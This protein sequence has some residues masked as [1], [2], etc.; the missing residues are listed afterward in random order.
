M[1]EY[2]TIIGKLLSGVKRKQFKRIV[3]KYDGDKYVKYFNCWSQ[4]VCIFIGQ[5]GNFKSLR[6]IVDAINFQPQNQ[7]HLGIKKNISRTTLAEANEKRDWRIYRDVFLKLIEKLPHW[8]RIETENVIKIMDSSPIQ[9]KLL[10]HPWVEKTQRIEGIKLHLLYDLTNTIPTYFEFSG[11]RTNDIEI[12]KRMDI[13]TGSTYVFDKGYMDFNWWNEIDDKGA[14]FVTRLKKNNAYD[15]LTPIQIHSDI[16]SSQII[17][18][19]RKRFKDGRY[20]Y[21]S[22]KPLRKVIVQR[23]GKSPLLLVTNDFNRSSEEIGELYKQRWQ[24]ELFF[25][26]IKQNLKIKNFLGRSENA[27]KTQIC[28]ALISFV[29]LHLMN[30]LKEICSEISTK[31]LLKIIGNNMFYTLKPRSAGRRRYKNPN[32]LQIEWILD[33]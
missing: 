32:Q 27:V 28:I 29:L 16:V 19:N 6:E 23:E 25:K 21:Y 7:Y 8:K 11:A 9:L 31:N 5:I 2:N 17:Q 14:Y 3:D 20:N 26:W 13:Q 33:G 22:D 24:I 12:G 15:E 1:Q 30:E 10:N 4:F 18:L